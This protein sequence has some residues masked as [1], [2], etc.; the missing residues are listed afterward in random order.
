[1]MN[2]DIQLKK[3]IKKHFLGLRD[4]R[5]TLQGNSVSNY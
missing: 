2:T 4:M 1:M 3:K 5:V